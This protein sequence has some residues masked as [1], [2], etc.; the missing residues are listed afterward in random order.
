MQKSLFSK[1][2]SVTVQLTV[3]KFSVVSF[4]L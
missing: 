1:E 3:S 2:N 4:L